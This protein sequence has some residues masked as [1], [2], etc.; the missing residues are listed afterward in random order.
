M[1]AHLGSFI[2]ST[3]KKIRTDFIREFTG[4]KTNNVYYSD[5]DSLYIENIYWDV[6]DKAKLVGENLCHCK[7]DY[8]N[9]GILYSLFFAPKIQ[10]CLTI[11]EY[12]VSEEH[13]TV[14]GFRDSQ[15]L[16]DRC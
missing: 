10:Y 11:D 16:L 9:C 8:E 5:T 14:R 2:L 3:I 15:R 4:F 12:G 7:S 6:V 13:K 1:P